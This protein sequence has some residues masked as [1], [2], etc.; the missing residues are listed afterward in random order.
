MTIEL[1]ELAHGALGKLVDDVV[2]VGGATVALWITDPAA[3]PVRVTEDVDVIVEV[4]R[5][6]AYYKFEESL[7]KAGFREEGQ[8]ICRWLHA[9]S[10]LVLDAMPA[11]ASILG[12]ENHWQRESL[13]HAVDVELP[14]G[15][16]I[17]A[18]PPA[19]LLA[20]KLEA[21]AGRGEGDMLASQD[22]ADIV[23]LTDGREELVGEVR[24]APRELRECVADQLG[25][26]VRGG[27]LLDGVYAQLRG[28]EASQRRAE[29]VVMVRVEEL[30]AAGSS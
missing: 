22:F 8:V 28:D 14:S 3:P 25:G 17:R 16:R 21:F 4:T 30:I 10:D 23:A 29:E 6:S 7:R 1:L 11:D 20:T 26:L 24:A 13:P 5:R 9:D 12:F 18:V 15:A 2:F 27:R 19:Y